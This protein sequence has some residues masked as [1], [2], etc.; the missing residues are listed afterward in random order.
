MPGSI[1]IMHH[2]GDVH[3]NERRIE[4]EIRE[5]LHDN[6]TTLLDYEIEI[7]KY[8]NIEKILNYENFKNMESVDIDEKIHKTLKNEDLIKEG[9]YDIFIIFNKINHYKSK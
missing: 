4:N 2:K 3:V 5:I 8:S 7:I 1:I 9:K 6:M